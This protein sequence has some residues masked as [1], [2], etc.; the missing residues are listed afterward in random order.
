MLTAFRALLTAALIIGAATSAF[1]AT[2]FEV[3]ARAFGAKCD[4]VT[5]DTTALQKAIDATPNGGVLVFHGSCVSGNLQISNKSNAVLRGDGAQIT[6]TGTAGASTYIGFQL[7][8]TVTNL[9]IDGFRLVGDGVAANGHAGIWN[10][11]GQTLTNIKVLRNHISNVAVG[12]SVN[13]D[14]A[15]S[16]LGATISHNYIDTVVG[17]SSGQGYGIH[18]A[19]ASSAAM[20]AKVT[21]N[22]IV[23]A[24]RHSIYVA[25]GNTALV[26]NNTIRN[27]RT[28][29]ADGSVRPAITTGRSQDVTIANNIID[30]PSDGGIEV[31]A[32]A[33]FTTRN[34]TVVNNKIVSPQNAVPA[35]VVG[36]ADPATEGTPDLVFLRGN[37]VYETAGASHA[38]HVYSGKRVRVQ[39]NSFTIIGNTTAALPL[40]KIEAAGDSGASATYTDD[41]L[42][43]NNL[44]YATNSGGGSTHA[45][46]LDSAFCTSIARAD[47]RGN[48]TI[49]PNATFLTAANI[50][51]PNLGLF[52]QA[53][54]GVSFA[55]NITFARIRATATATLD[56]NIGAAATQDLNTTA[57]LGVPPTAA[58]TVSPPG[59][60]NV[61]IVFTA[62]PHS[63]NGSIWV[64]GANVTAAGV[65]PASSVF[66][67]VAEKH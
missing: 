18:V 22:I 62:Y 20:H 44:F 50:T 27:H 61:G 46:R 35:L 63:T 48:R 47:F 13:A 1:A 25:K 3:D 30:K 26:A 6:W 66:G 55:A 49:V 16:L 17:T 4:G 5:V 15:G 32:A 42:V 54:D 14:T 11:S 21:D 19:S 2:P 31:F 64:R 67:L 52:D 57:I 36:V 65:D 60:I 7:V 33:T 56:F 8:G 45:F 23:A 38:L 39:D 9:T 53:F 10:A 12:I 58:I 28:A 24:Q 43:E 59:N 29:V 41:L 51:N 37:E 40:V 34:I